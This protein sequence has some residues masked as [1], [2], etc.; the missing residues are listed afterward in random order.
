MTEVREIVAYLS[1]GKWYKAAEVQTKRHADR[2]A[3][4]D[5]FPYTIAS[6]RNRQEYGRDVPE[7]INLDKQGSQGK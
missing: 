6:L 1:K 7:W 4:T 5:A 2:G 3:F